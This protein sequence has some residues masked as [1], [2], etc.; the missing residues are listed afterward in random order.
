M[1]KE[2]KTQ[3]NAEEKPGPDRNRRQFFNS[4]GKWSLAVV[5]AVAGL[6]EKLYS[7]DVE[8]RVGPLPDARFGDREPRQQI[9]SKK[10]THKQGYYKGWTNATQWKDDIVTP[11][12]GSPGRLVPPAGPEPKTHQ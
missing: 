12:S 6:R 3:P 2:T 8:N 7:S 5:A 1:D 10:S 9:A 4:L 11:R